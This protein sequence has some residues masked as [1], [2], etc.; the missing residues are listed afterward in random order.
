MMSNHKTSRTTGWIVALILLCAPFSLVAGTLTP[1]TG[2]EAIPSETVGGAFTALSGPVYDEASRGEVDVGTIVLELPPGFEW[3]TAITPVI[4][5]TRLNPT[6]PGGRNINDLPDGGTFAASSVTATAITFQITTTSTAQR[7]NRITVEGLEVRPTQVSPEASGHIVHTGTSNINN[8]TTGVTSWGYLE[9]QPDDSDE[10]DHYRISMPGQGITCATTPITIEARDAD[11][12]AVNPDAGTVVTLSSDLVSG[13]W[14]T[15]FAGAG[16]F[17]GGPDGQA[18]YEFLGDESGFQVGYDYTAIPADP[19]SVVPTAGDN[20]G[21][22]SV[23]DPAALIMTRAGFRFVD[24]DSGNAIIPFQIAGKPSATGYNAADLG[25]QAIRESDN[26]PTTCQGI[27]ASG[28]TAPV[29]LGAE[30]RDPAVCGPQAMSINGVPIATSNDNGDGQSAVAYTE[31]NLS[32][33]ADATAALDLQYFDAGA[34]RLYAAAQ[35]RRGDDSESGDFITGGS[36]EFVVRPF[37]FEVRAPGDAG[38]SP[39]PDGAELV[40]AGEDFTVELRAVGWLPGQDGNGDGS[41]DP[42]VDLSGNATT[43]N[44]GNESVAPVVQLA[45]EVAAPVGGDDGILSNASIDGFAAGEAS[46]ADLR[47]SEVGYVHLNA[48]LINYLGAGSVLGSGRDIGRFIP[49]RYQ[50]T[51]LADPDLTVSCTANTEFNYLTQP[52]AWPANDGPRIQVTAVNAGGVQTR[53]ARDDYWRFDELTG[54]DF[55]QGSTFRYRDDG[56]PTAHEDDLAINAS[57]V[58]LLDGI[59]ED[60]GEGQ[61]NVQL[62]GALGHDWDHD[63][64]EAPMVAP[65]TSDLLVEIRIRDLDD[66]EYEDE[67]GW[68]ELALPVANDAEQRHGRLNIRPAHGSDLLDLNVPVV[69]EYYVDET[70]GWRT[71]TDDACSDGLTLRLEPASGAIAPGDT[72]AYDPANDS[73]IDC[74]AEDGGAMNWNPIAQA[75]D[76]N[77]WLQAPN[78]TGSLLLCIQDP[79]DADACHQPGASGNIPDALRFDWAG[80]SEH[81]QAP[82][83]RVTFGIHSGQD[84]RIDLRE[85]W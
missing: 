43:A 45:P 57:L 5:V 11:G 17:V 1:A 47:W 50:V 30:C 56:L 12:N 29:E 52:M 82:Q 75:G 32:F 18:T 73:G 9:Q 61:S 19:T 26:D 31:L 68:Y 60:V 35:I 59:L 53:N 64:G 48:E 25:L 4:R 6:F 49:H 24:R 27:Y 54:F 38:E 85:A 67:N 81:N 15:L 63:T 44:F 80:D 42:G 23:T 74:D 71:H 51:T 83:T 79:D 37:G 8:V 22:G 41:P 77:L 2:G 65:F 16:D 13:Y 20:D 55:A 7:H 58:D 69:A 84:R 46:R 33:G 36:N 66:V 70:T 39:A 21:N 28:E 76:F 34:M 10:V 14:S 62:G 78:T 40:A 3:N 72:C